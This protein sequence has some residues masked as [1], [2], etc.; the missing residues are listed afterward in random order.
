MKFETERMPTACGA[1]PV[2]SA[3]RVGEHS[4]VT[5]K[6]VNCRPFAARASMF[7]VSMS[8]PKQPNWA[9]P[10]SSMRMRITFG[11]SSPGCGGTANHGSDSATVRP[12]FPWNSFL[13]T[14][15]IPL[16]CRRT[17]RLHRH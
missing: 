7:G 11:A 6:L 10:V 4:G 8:E 16:P 12:I 14:I 17:E 9:K 15:A 2:R 1:R 3:A 5:W 13:T